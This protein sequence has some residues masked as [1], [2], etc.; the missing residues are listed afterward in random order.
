MLG[1]N[2]FDLDPIFC[3]FSNFF[4]LKKLHKAFRLRPVKPQTKAIFD[5]QQLLLVGK[6]DFKIEIILENQS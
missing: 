3:N 1:K 6:C 5:R 2:V 4:Q